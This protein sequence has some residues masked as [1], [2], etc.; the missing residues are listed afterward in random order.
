MSN[1]TTTNNWLQKTLQNL[2]RGGF[3]VSENVGLSDGVARAVARRTSIELTKFGFSETFFVFREF[4]SLTTAALRKFSS[5]A[6]DL[7]KRSKKIPLPCGLFES[8]WCFAVAIA[9]QLENTAADSVRNDA[10]AK[11]MAAAEIPVVFHVPKGRLYYFERTPVWG[12][13]YYRGFRKK[14]K[15]YLDL[16]GGA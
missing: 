13:A 3:V 12:A 4:E 15:R 8:V 10:P 16:A 6:F 7:A 9:N 1:P 2:A 5:D 14:I 11:H